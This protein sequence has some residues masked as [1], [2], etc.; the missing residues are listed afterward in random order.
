[1]PGTPVGFPWNKNPFK[2]SAC[3]PFLPGNLRG[4]IHGRT[5]RHYE[6]REASGPVSQLRIFSTAQHK[7]LFFNMLRGSAGRLSRTGGRESGKNLVKILQVN[8]RKCLKPQTVT[9]RTKYQN[10]PFDYK[11]NK[12][13]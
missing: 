11:L 3:L 1:M 9:A 10:Q 8:M 13:K 12:T 5:S 4:S 7:Q 2:R 6:D